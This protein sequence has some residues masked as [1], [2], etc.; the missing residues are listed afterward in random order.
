MIQS[1]LSQGE[2]HGFST[3][4]VFREKRE[5]QESE[6]YNG[7]IFFHEVQNNHLTVRAFRESGEPVG[8][9]LSNPTDAAM[10]RAFSQVGAVNIP[11]QK[12]NFAAYLPVSVQKIGTNIFDPAVESFG[13]KNFETLLEKLDEHLQKFPDLSL[14]KVRLLKI[15]KKVY[16]ANTNGL[17]GKYKKSQF[18]LIMNLAAGDN[19]VEISENKIYF[20]QLDPERMIIRGDNLLRSLT[21]RPDKDAKIRYLILAPEA[22]AIILKEFSHHFKLKEQNR[23]PNML[24]S[25]V[26]NIVDDPSLDGQSGSVIFDDEGVQSR[27]AYIIKKG[28]FSGGISNVETAFLNNRSSSGNGFRSAVTP[29]PQVQFSNLYIKPTVLGLNTLMKEAGRG[30][31]VSLAKVKHIERDGIVFSAYGYRFRGAERGQPV[32]FYFKTSFL[33]YFMKVLKVSKEIKFFHSQFNV[34]SPYLLVEGKYKSP[35]IFG[36]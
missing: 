7:H 3:V 4:E 8:F 6:K 15:L 5:Q 26:L 36:I 1:I 11:D 17:N 25:P 23:L 18:N 29:F 33:S 16:V 34:G 28:A 30:I 10:K 35:S 22:S 9:H 31:L 21:D 13:R 12:P 14:R 2:K 24:F 32:H 19:M 27:G 20:A